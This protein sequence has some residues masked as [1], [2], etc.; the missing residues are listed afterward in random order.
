VL[1]RH[2]LFRPPHSVC[3][4]DY[5]DLNRI[6]AWWLTHFHRYY[7]EYST[8]FSSS[9]NNVLLTAALPRNHQEIGLGEGKATDKGDVLKMLQ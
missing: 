4:F 3:V 2:S 5:E 6:T 8:V 1:V 7:E 9:L